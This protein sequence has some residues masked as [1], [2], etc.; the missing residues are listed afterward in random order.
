MTVQPGIDLAPLNPTYILDY[1]DQCDRC[2][3]RAYVQT[4]IA[5]GGSLYWCR[6]HW[7][8]YRRK[9]EAISVHT[10]D[11]TRA[12]FNGVKDDRWVVEGKAQTL[13]PPEPNH[14]IKE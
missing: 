13:P 7:N 2:G 11:E 8:Q 3:A 10:N 14:G 5:A 6:H 9:L 4:V 12:L 1:T